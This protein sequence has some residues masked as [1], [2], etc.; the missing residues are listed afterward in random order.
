[1]E[2]EGEEEV[3]EGEEEDHRTVTEW[4]LSKLPSLGVVPLLLVVVVVV[5]MVV[6]VVVVV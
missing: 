6:V 1:M 5:V 4:C 3:E 2:E